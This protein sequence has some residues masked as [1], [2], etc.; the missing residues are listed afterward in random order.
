MDP[1]LISAASGMNARMEALDLLA[2]NIA[3]TSTAGYKADREF[4]TLFQSQLPLIQRQWTDYSQGN[5]TSTGNPLNLG[6]AGPGFF[7]LN[8]PTGM[9]YTRN[10]A[11]MIS[12]SNQLQTVEGYT[13]R[14]TRDQGKPIVVDPTQAVD[15]D[16]DGVVRQGG[17]E[18]GKIEIVNIDDAQT[19]LKKQG[20]SY[21]ALSSTAATP[22]PVTATDVVQGTLEMSN[23]P[24]SEQGVRLVSIMR[25]FEMLQRAMVVG[26]NMDKQAIQEVAKVT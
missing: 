1:L 16:K 26:T 8:T 2:N 22:K 10:G 15:I 21:Y 5:I 20:G 25:Q 11:F 7:A 13:L 23:V 14:N 18:L 17:T 6:L 12:K 24:A 9:L 19:E 3:N 4:N